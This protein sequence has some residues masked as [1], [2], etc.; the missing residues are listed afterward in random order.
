MSDAAKMSRSI[1][2]LAATQRTIVTHEQLLARGLGRKAIAYWRQAGRLHVVFRGVYSY[3]CGVLPPWGREQ[4]ALLACGERAFLSHLTSG[5]LWGLIPDPPK[6]PN[7]SLLNGEGWP[8]IGICVHRV[9]AVDPRELRRKDGLPL[10]SPAR[11]LIEI[12]A[13]AA[14]DELEQ[15]FDQAFARKLVFARELRA[16]LACHPGSRGSARLRALLDEGE[17]HG[18]TRSW[19]ERRLRA[20]LR[21]VGLVQPEANAQIGPYV[22]DFVW[23]ELRLIVEFDGFDFHNGRQMFESDRERDAALKAAGWEVIRF[24]WRQLQYQPE[25]V[26]FRLGQI[27]AAVSRRARAG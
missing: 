15:G 5:A 19:G 12:A 23:R 18:M 1:G 14:K 10:S 16:V 9:A 7:V 8:R 24:T 17:N 22:V 6:E 27:M 21:K 25:L 11:A 13:T 2:E 26:M 4:A 20:L 3:G